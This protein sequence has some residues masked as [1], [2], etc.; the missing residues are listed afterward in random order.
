MIAVLE[1]IV[2]LVGVTLAAC[3]AGQLVGWVMH[4]F[5]LLGVFNLYPVLAVAVIA[6]VLAS[7]VHATL[8]ITGA[9]VATVALGVTVTAGVRRRSHAL[10]GGGAL[11]A[12]ELSRRW[13]WQP[14]PQRAAGEHV[15]LGRQ[16]EVVHVRPWRADV[17]YVSARASRASRISRGVVGPRLPL[18]E[19][20]HVFLVGATGAGKTTTARRLLAARVLAQHSSLVILDQKGDVQDVAE[21]R[22]LA[23]AAGVPF[24]LFDSQDPDT[25]RWQPLWGTPG[26][27]AARATEAI[28]E[29]EPYYYD[30][31]RK[32]LDV[33]CTVLHAADRWP[34]S[35]PFLIDACQPAHYPVLLAIA[36]RE[37]GNDEALLRRAERHAVWVASRKGTEDLAGG[38]LRLETALALASSRVVT[39]RLTPDGE[40]VAVGLQQGLRERAVIMFRTHADTMPDEAAALTTVAL[41]DLHAAAESDVG[42]WTLLLDE[43]GAVISTAADR[44]LAIL[45]RG[46]THHGQAILITQSVAD[47]EALTGTTGLLDSLADNFAAIIAHRQ[48]SPDSRDWLSRMMGTRE[49]WQHTNQT[50]GHGARLSGRGS[51]RRVHEFRV[52]PDVFAELDRGEAVIYSPEGQ[53]ADRTHITPVLLQRREPER[54]DRGGQRHRVEISVHPET[55]ISTPPPKTDEEAPDD[56]GDPPSETGEHPFNA[57]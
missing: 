4:K 7:V 33:I 46:R 25:D 52:P 40:T 17:A 29:S 53:Q 15:R 30:V 1:P 50:D 28:K 37:A 19:G 54:I 24:V 55:I 31:L 8:L 36:R 41:A 57:I 26:A 23:A 45:Q 12:H 35:V 6:L 34:P 42:P 43:F 27:V 47:I 16:G 10:G 18:G 14:A 44:A 20:Q 3:V 48:T 22:A 2:V 5:S 32:H 38:T 9:G 56:S 39:P 11:R 13:V 21:M 49:L 51:V